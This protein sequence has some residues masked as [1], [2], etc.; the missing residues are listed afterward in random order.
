MGGVLHGLSRRWRQQVGPYMS[1]LSAARTRGH[2]GRVGFTY[3]FIVAE[4]LIWKSVRVFCCRSKATFPLS[5][6][7]TYK[8]NRGIAPAV[9][10]W[11]L[12]RD[13][14][15]GLFLPGKEP[16]FACLNRRPGV[17]QSLTRHVEEE[18]HVVPRSGFE[19]RTVHSVA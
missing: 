5:T 18:K 17:S 2:A 9:L 14:R 7:E 11:V 8:G 19:L 1:L 12:Q 16:L 15:A 6:Q 10:S 13:R 3:V 4:Q